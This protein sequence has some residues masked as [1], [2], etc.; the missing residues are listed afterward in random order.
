MIKHSLVSEVLQEVY[1]L[2]CKFMM[3]AEDSIL[4]LFL[5]S[6]MRFKTLAYHDFDK[7]SNWFALHH[8]QEHLRLQGKINMQIK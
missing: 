4:L 5:L 6:K 2:F 7:R 3:S 1:A 8:Y